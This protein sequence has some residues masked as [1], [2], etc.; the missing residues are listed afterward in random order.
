MQQNFFFDSYVKVIKHNYFPGFQVFLE[1]L[2]EIDF[3]FLSDLAHMTKGENR[4]Y[5]IKFR[6]QL[7]DIF[8][9]K[10]FPSI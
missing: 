6:Y 8:Y 2:R 7:N 5:K 4:A 10:V 9:S 3:S 1:N